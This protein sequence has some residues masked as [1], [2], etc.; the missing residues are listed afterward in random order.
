MVTLDVVA[1]LLARAIAKAE[2]TT[3]EAVLEEAI[4]ATR[5]DTAPRREPEDTDAIEEIYAL[6]PGKCPISGRSTGKCS[7]NKKQ[8]A[9]L[10]KTR[11][12]QD[13]KDTM[14]SYLEDCKS[15]STYIKNFSTLL[16][17]FP[18]KKA[19]PTAPP[20]QV[21]PS[22]DIWDDPLYQQWKEK[23]QDNQ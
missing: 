4:Q 3:A 12:L 11:D 18:E 22:Q 17:Q 9:T 13:I 5:R 21:A 1:Y 8:I 7:K 23:Q 6:Y 15:S 2:N 10:L 20:K 16:N 14:L 19:A